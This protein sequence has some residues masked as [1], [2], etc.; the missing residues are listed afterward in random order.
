MPQRTAYWRL[1]PTNVE[2]VDLLSRRDNTELEDYD[3]LQPGDP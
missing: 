2:S 1:L 3:P